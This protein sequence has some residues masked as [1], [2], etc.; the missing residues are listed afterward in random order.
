MRPRFPIPNKGLRKK[1]IKKI[2]TLIQL[3]FG[4]LRMKKMNS[5]C[6][7]K[8]TKAKMMNVPRWPFCILSSE[9]SI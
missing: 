8:L 6:L 3:N 7:K 9:P 2:A 4:I 1:K 5:S